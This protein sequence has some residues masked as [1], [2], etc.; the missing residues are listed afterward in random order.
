MKLIETDKLNNVEGL[1]A[2]PVEQAKD[3]IQEVMKDIDDT[4]CMMILEI[5]KNGDCKLHNTDIQRGQLAFFI[6][7]LDLMYINDME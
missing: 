1:N 7:E 2:H 3:I 4:K 6:K 5:K